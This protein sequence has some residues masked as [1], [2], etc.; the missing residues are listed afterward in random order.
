MSELYRIKLDIFEGPMDLL[1][2]LIQK[3]ELDITDIP[4]RL[5]TDQYLSYLDM[6]RAMNVDLAADFLLM[7]A[8]L[9]QIK[10][11]MLLPTHE[12]DPEEDPRLELTR[13]LLEY[14][15]LKEAATALEEKATE[16]GFS[17]PRGSSFQP[18]GETEVFQTLEIF[19]LVKAF[20]NVLQNLD[21][22]DTVV[23]IADEISIQD[24]MNEIIALLEEESSVLFEDLFKY[25]KTKMAMVITF[26]AIL[27][28]AK[29]AIIRIVQSVETK[30]IRIFYQ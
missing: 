24:R 26:L 4:I 22:P 12:G 13:P 18:E 16:T 15:Q 27:E 10:S 30:R 19:D 23:V 29:I 6:M 7:A 9:V 14:L 25:S 8:T 5:I 21:L 17:S 1:L 3:H 11:R 2:F 20:Q 28:L